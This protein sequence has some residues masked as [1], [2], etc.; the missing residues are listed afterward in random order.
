MKV[1][2]ILFDVKNSEINKVEDYIFAIDLKFLIKFGRPTGNQAMA[3]G[4]P[5]ENPRFKVA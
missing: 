2:F 5:S 4:P 3:C 1:I